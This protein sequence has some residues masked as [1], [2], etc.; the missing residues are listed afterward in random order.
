MPSRGALLAIAFFLLSAIASALYEDQA[1]AVDWHRQWIGNVQSAVLEPADKKSALQSSLVFVASSGN[2][3]AALRARTGH[4]VWRHVLPEDEAFNFFLHFDKYLLSVH[5]SGNV[6]RMWSASEGSLLW[7]LGTHSDHKSARYLAYPLREIKEQNDSLPSAWRD[8]DVASISSHKNKHVLLLHHNTVRC[9][10]AQNAQEAWT[11]KLESPEEGY[12]ARRL[13]VLNDKIY[14]IGTSAN[15][16]K[17]IIVELSAKGTQ[18]STSTISLTSPLSSHAL[19]LSSGY[20]VALEGASLSIHKIDDA[21]FVQQVPLKSLI[22]E[23]MPQALLNIDLPNRFV[24]MTKSNR[25]VIAMSVS[26]TSLKLH[27]LSSYPLE[28]DESDVF[29]AE[30]C[31]ESEYVVRVAAS[32][33]NAAT[34][35]EVTL[36]VMVS[37]WNRQG[38]QSAGKDLTASITGFASHG[39]SLR[40]AFFRIA[41][42]INVYRILIVAEDH[43]LSLI[44][45]GRV[46]W[47]R[48]EALASLIDTH[49]VEVPVRSSFHQE[50]FPSLMERI[51]PQLR[52]IMNTVMDQVSWLRRSIHALMTTGSAMLEDTDEDIATANP[53]KQSLQD[54]F[55]FKKMLVA[56]TSVGKLYGIDSENGDIVWQHYA[57]EKDN[58][59]SLRAWQLILSPHSSGHSRNCYALFRG[60][61]MTVVHYYDSLQGL[62]SYSAELPFS[63]QEAV[64][65]PLLGT[66]PSTTASSSSASPSSEHLLML[67]DPL[68]TLHIVPESKE[69]L[70][71]FIQRH[72]SSS[73][74]SSASS[75]SPSMPR[76]F[77]FEV[78]LSEQSIKGYTTALSSSA[79]PIAQH[80]WTVAFPKD[81]EK[82]SAVATHPRETIQSTVRLLKVDQ[83][84]VY[85]YLNPHLLAVATVRDVPSSSA[86]RSIMKKVQM[87]P[88]IV[89]YLIDTVTGAI[90]E[91]TV[92]RN[93][94]GPVHMTLSENLIFFHHWNAHSLQ[95]EFSVMELEEP[96]QQA[97]MIAS[98]ESLTSSAL[99][100]APIV[101]Q[102]SY[103][104][105]SPISAIGVTQTKR[106]I[107]AKDVIVALRSGQILNIPSPFLDTHRPLDESIMANPQTMGQLHEE[108]I[109]P[110]FT[111][112]PSDPA[113][114]ISYNLEIL[115]VKKIMSAPTLL[116]STSVVCTSGLDLF[117]TRVTP[118]QTFDQLGEEFNYIFLIA[119]VSLV[120]AAIVISSCFVKKRL[121][122][123]AWAD[124]KMKQN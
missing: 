81:T 78:S 113:S 8:F 19:L 41:E 42:S 111:E 67:V 106:G 115:R 16:N 54:P 38:T 71:L 96:Q 117:C 33:K 61:D 72:S 18:E 74:S 75:S 30:S 23:A 40:R 20:L 79:R 51:Q 12:V 36:G 76:L 82:I 98:E 11:W 27:L 37:K 17:L 10:A 22:G 101:H 91:K 24:V 48:E 15:M 57:L 86:V 70:Q 120:M 21:K 26:G 104:F 35:H 100:P 124:I 84:V 62:L 44:Q 95:Y 65:L 34:A 80:L 122:K 64:L 89:I 77:F 119:T 107:A 1:G 56:L 43:S 45:N 68:H 103:T 110:Y 92:H 69:N 121:L 83:T 105:R 52:L 85:K 46:L 90:L 87:D 29:T 109:A 60:N 123:D 94:Q 39:K 63:T 58:H 73:S 28:Q 3:L 5:D 4:I 14:V 9:M 53:N 88:C 55:G 32:K 93:G 47:T 25:A 49:L 31:E 116:E 13:I 112:I 7:D 6:I 118:S 50:D 59:S 97:A 99:R 108:G 66:I 114:I 2:V 102:Q